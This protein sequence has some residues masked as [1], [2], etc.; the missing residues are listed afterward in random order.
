MGFKGQCAGFTLLE[1]LLVMAVLGLLVTLGAPQLQHLWHT[2]QMYSAFWQLQQDLNLARHAAV[3]ERRPVLLG[4]H[5]EGWQAGWVMFVDHNRNGRWDD[6]ERQLGHGAALRGVLLR[7]N[8]PVSQYVRF[9][10]HGGTELLGGGFQAGTLTLCHASGRQPIR[11][12]VISASG[13]LRSEQ[14]EAGHC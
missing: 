1:T 3:S 6:G 10:P 2:Q 11:R 14:G 13:R 7:G 8:A 5:A 4:A 9:M 12:L